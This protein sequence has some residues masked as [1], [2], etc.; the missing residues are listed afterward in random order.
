MKLTPVLCN[1]KIRKSEWPKDE[2]LKVIFVGR[3]FSVCIDQASKECV[4]PYDKNDDT[5]I[6]L[7]PHIPLKQEKETEIEEVE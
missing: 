5:W 2:W 4:L 1:R 6:L 7:N 3:D